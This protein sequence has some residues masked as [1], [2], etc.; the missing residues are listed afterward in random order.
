MF[1]FVGVFVFALFIGLCFGWLIPLVIGLVKVS[2]K[3][4]GKGWLIGSGVWAFCALVVVGLSVFSVVSAQRR[5]ATEVFNE[6]NYA[7]DRATLI[8][9]FS[10]SGSLTLRQVAENKSWQVSFSNTNSVVVP[11]GVMRIWHLS[12]EIKN[13]EGEFS[14][15]MNC[16]FASNEDLVAKAGDVLT[17][18]GGTPFT[19]A[20]TAKRADGD[21]LKIAYSLTDVAGNRIT[22]WGVNSNNKKP[23]FEAIGPDGSCFW[24]DHLEY[25]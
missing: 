24:S 25:G 20:I 18:S 12:Y 11:A 2:R 10:G 3:S 5:M 13:K 1:F 23:K 16:S 22:Y 9:P 15:G 14:G 8:L 19:A 4:G 21:K 6:A 17:L 7:G